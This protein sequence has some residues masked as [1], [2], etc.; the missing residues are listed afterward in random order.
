MV[1]VFYFLWTVAGGIALFSLSI[2]V[3]GLSGLGVWELLKSFGRK[4]STWFNKRPWTTILLTIMIY[5]TI[6]Q[7]I[8]EK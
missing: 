5:G 7:M 8:L 2:W 1:E 6:V 3:I 4:Y